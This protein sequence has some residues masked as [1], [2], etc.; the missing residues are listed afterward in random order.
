MA[1]DRCKG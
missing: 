1:Q